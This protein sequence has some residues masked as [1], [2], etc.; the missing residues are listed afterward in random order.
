MKQHQVPGRR[1]WRAL[2]AV[3]ALCLAFA[4]G[5]VMRRV[6]EA[7]TNIVAV[8]TTDH[9]AWNDIVG[10]T[11]F[12]NTNTASVLDTQLIG[13]ASSSVGDISLDCATTRNGSVCGTSNYGVYNDAIGDLSGYGWNDT[14]GWVSFCGGLS[15][16]TCPGTIAY[17]AQIDPLTGIFKGNSYNYAWNDIAGWISFNCQNGGPGGSSICATSP[18]RVVTTWRAAPTTGT[19][20]S[21]TYDTAVSQGAQLNSLLW[22]GS[23]PPGTSVGFQVA[24]STSP[25]GP[26][27]FAGSDGTSNTYYTAAPGVSAPLDYI[28]FAG[29]RYFRY[30]VTLFSDLAKTVSPRVDDV[31]IN[32]SP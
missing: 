10:W 22:H 21:T 17:Q 25:S 12:Y 15:T 23:L 14:Y 28:L 20:D 16:I 8:P 29:A 6:V 1:I 31:I 5:F 7:A 19:L 24:T 3:C 26:W 27:N 4:A 13:Y 30:R 9:W 32:W 11:D 2:G 18:Y